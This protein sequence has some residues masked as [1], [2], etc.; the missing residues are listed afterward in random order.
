MM[1][2]DILECTVGADVKKYSIWRV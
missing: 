2:V 1:Y